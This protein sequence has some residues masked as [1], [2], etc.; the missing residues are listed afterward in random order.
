MRDPEVVGDLFA[1]DHGRAKKRMPDLIV[2]VDNRGQVWRTQIEERI[3]PP[4]RIAFSRS[5]RS[6][7]AIAPSAARTPETKRA[8]QVEA[9]PEHQGAIARVNELYT[10]V[11]L[12]VTQLPCT[13]TV[14]GCPSLRSNGGILSR[15]AGL[16]P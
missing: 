16:P 1:L 6:C 7:A 13:R 11:L 5:Q 15:T 14:L 4:Q 12:V 2:C 10:E 3:G 9:K 8:A